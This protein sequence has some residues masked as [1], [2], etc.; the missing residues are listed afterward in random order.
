MIIFIPYS[1]EEVFSDGYHYTDDFKTWMLENIG[2]GGYTN[3]KYFDRIFDSKKNIEWVCDWSS[4]GEYF[5]F[6]DINHI[7]LFKLTWG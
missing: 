1:N 5:K 6:K 4:E 7:I 3:R 2:V